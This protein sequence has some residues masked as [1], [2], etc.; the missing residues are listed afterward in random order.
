MLRLSCL[1]LLHTADFSVQLDRLLKLLLALLLVQILVHPRAAWEAV[2]RHYHSSR[3]LLVASILVRTLRARQCRL[4]LALDR[5][6]ASA[7][8]VLHPC[9][10]RRSLPALDHS[11]GQ[12][13]FEVVDEPQH[14]HRPVFLVDR[15]PHVLELAPVFVS[16]R[17]IVSL[18]LC[19]PLFLRGIDDFEAKLSFRSL[20]RSVLRQ[21]GWHGCRLGDPRESRLS[22]T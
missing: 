9:L 3:V 11:Q 14:L 18:R 12:P 2:Q 6:G 22:R 4:G 8:H 13:A 15:T 16:L 5:A 10:R 17:A 1:L 19:R 20:R 21:F 7:T